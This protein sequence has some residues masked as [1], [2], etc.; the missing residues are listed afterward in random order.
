MISQVSAIEECQPN[1][2]ITGLYDTA[3]INSC[4]FMTI[5]TST[6][7]STINHSCIYIYTYYIGQYPYILKGNVCYM[8]W[9]I[10]EYMFKY[11]LCT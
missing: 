11:H 1:I 9:S 5:I 8:K 3:L 7:V 10:S 6:C 4:I 2:T